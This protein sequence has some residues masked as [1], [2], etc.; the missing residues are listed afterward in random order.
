MK[1]W[2]CQIWTI[3]YNTSYS[4]IEGPFMFQK[5]QIKMLPIYVYSS[6]WRIELW[7]MRYPWILKQSIID[8]DPLCFFLQKI[9]TKSWDPKII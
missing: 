2:T 6:F 3:Q 1:T 8:F 5:G 7:I 9:Y 4:K